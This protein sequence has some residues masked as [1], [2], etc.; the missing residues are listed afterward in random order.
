MTG[1]LDVSD[2]LRIFSQHRDEKPL[3]VQDDHRERKR[4][5]APR[6]APLYVQRHEIVGRNP[7][8]V[9]KGPATI[10]KPSNGV[11]PPASIEPT[12]QL[13]PGHAITG[14]GARTLSSVND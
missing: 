2:P 1:S 14:K 10:E 11:G 3:S 4:N 9:D 7:A 8:R 6:S 5:R 13:S 12:M